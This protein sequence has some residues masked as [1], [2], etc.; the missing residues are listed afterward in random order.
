MRTTC[1]AIGKT[2]IKVHW[3]KYVEG[4]SAGT[5][6]PVG[7]LSLEA[8]RT[9]TDANRNFQVDCDLTNVDAQ[10][11]RGAG[12]DFC[13]A[14][15]NRNF[16][17]ATPSTARDPDTYLGWGN[18]PWNQTFSVGIQREI[19]PRVAIDVG[20]FRRWSGNFIV[21]DNR[22]VTASDFTPYSV[23][24]PAQFP[25]ATIPLPD[26]AA[27]R[28]TSGF[29][30]VNPNK[31]GVVDNYV[32]LA[33]KAGVGDQSQTWNGVDV[34]VNAR[35]TNG[36]VVQGG[37]ST[38][39]QVTDNCAVRDAMPEI[40]PTNPYCRVGQEFQ[41]QVKFL[42]TYL[43]PRVDVQFGVTF[44]SSPGPSIAAN[45]FVPVANI[46]GL[47]RPL[48]SGAPTVMYNL[49][50]PNSLYGER[51][52]QL[53]LRMSK[54]FRVGPNRI[55]LNFDLA[56]LLNSQRRSRC[57]DHVRPGLADTA[58]DHGPAALQVRRA[59]RLL[60][61]ELPTSNVQLQKRRTRFWELDVWE[62]GVR[63]WELAVEVS[64][65]GRDARDLPSLPHRRAP[66]TACR[67]PGGRGAVVSK[68]KDLGGILERR[69]GTT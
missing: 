33:K 3:G 29:Y 61:T 50:D 53:D 19:M 25:G 6:N 48:T 5:G 63:S 54:I 9:W 22:A 59:V 57:V 12:G 52:N 30:D 28:T 49:I 51:A 37:F 47:G 20:Y 64:I 42:G 11:N 23:T 45:F 21:T 39:K 66:T 8:T 58:G 56:N 32:T 1:S 68:R 60:I 31:F 13:G 41:T 27:G 38:G 4:L 35:A 40:A 7:N 67:Q 10:D 18:R 69:L 26:D 65:L 15:P 46:S 24:A 17:L 36:I 44:Q 62:L 16:G 55:Q 2:A 43:I 34:T 14:N